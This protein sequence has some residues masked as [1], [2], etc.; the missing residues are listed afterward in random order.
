MAHSTV[1]VGVHEV[2]LYDTVQPSYQVLLVMT[3][4]LAVTGSESL[5]VVV[6]ARHQLLKWFPSN[7]IA[8]RYT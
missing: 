4:D 6:P 8:V 1:K 3:A 2:D 5:G 7:H